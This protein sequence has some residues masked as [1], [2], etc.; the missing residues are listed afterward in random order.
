MS[1]LTVDNLNTSGNI[2][3]SGTVSC[4]NLNVTGSIT[5]E[6]VIAQ[7][8]V[9]TGSVLEDLSFQS[10]G[11]NLVTQQ[12]TITKPDNSSFVT[13]NTFH[14]LTGSWADIP[15]TEFSY[16]PPTGTKHVRIEWTAL[17]VEASGND[18]GGIIPFVDGTAITKQQQYVGW[19]NGT[20][21]SHHL[22]HYILIDVVGSGA[23]A[24]N[25]QLNT[26]SEA[27]QIKFQGM[28]GGGTLRLYQGTFGM[29]YPNVTSGANTFAQHSYWRLTAIT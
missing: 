14:D 15:G 25:G 2:T 20:V 18:R 16:Q 19:H 13:G 11:T 23:V 10:D 22:I 26:W 29:Q 27:K 21:G 4:D 9:P 7:T 3:T 8:N 5:Y 1:N 28:D 17:W 12:G 24:A 6:N